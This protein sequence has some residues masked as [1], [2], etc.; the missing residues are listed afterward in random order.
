MLPIRNKSQIYETYLGVLAVLYKLCGIKY[1]GRPVVQWFRRFCPE[2]FSLPWT[3]DHKETLKAAIAGWMFVPTSEALPHQYT[4]LIAEIHADPEP[5]ITQVIISVAKIH[6][7]IINKH[8][9]DVCILEDT[10]KK[11]ARIY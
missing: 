7:G 4:R 2:L 8:D 6:Y 1:P 9:A 10:V 3:E 5:D 11:Y